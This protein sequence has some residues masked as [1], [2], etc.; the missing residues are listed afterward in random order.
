MLEWLRRRTER[1]EKRSSY[2]SVAVQALHEAV[3]NKVTDAA[4]SAAVEAVSGLLARSLSAA[5]VDAPDFLKGALNPSWL[6]LVAREMLRFGE[7]LSVIRVGMDG[8]VRLE[9]STYWNWR[10]PHG[11]ENWRALATISGPN[12]TRTREYERDGV[13]WVPWARLSDQ[14]HRGRGP[15]SLASLTARAA[16]ES[17]RSLADESSGP[18]SQ[19]LT[20]PDGY[21]GDDPEFGGL[22]SQI[23]K[24]R[25]KA[26]L[27]ET[28]AGGYAD[29]G[30]AP[31][32]D[33]VAQRLGP[34]MPPALVELARDTFGRLCAACGAS[35]SLFVDRDGT[36]MRE[37]WRRFHLATVLPVAGLLEHELS[38][39]FDTPVSFNFDLYATDIVGRAMAFQRLVSGGMSVEKAAAISGILTPG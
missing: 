21:S 30:G 12:E 38:E 23:A 24:A 3:E 25:G 39:R 16:A 14:P 31:A 18:V 17:E 15:A 5:R 9:P 29:K 22:L 34:N 36:A 19:F 2:S 13:V 6:S 26:L 7:H 32:K 35:E 33:W 11:E 27:L 37:A 8:M 28:T 10:G 20:V 4:S 1:T